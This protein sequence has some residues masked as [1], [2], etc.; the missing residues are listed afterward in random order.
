MSVY[1][2]YLESIVIR[3][4]IAYSEISHSYEFLSWGLRTCLEHP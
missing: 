2:Y 1:F 3:N 4:R